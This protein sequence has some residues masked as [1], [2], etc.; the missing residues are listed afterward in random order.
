MSQYFIDTLV[1][2]PAPKLMS[3]LRCLI[4]CEKWAQCSAVMKHKL[5]Y[6]TA[7][8]TFGG[9]NVSASSS[10]PAKCVKLSGINKW[11]LEIWLIK[12]FSETLTFD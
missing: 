5:Q 3:P 7:K 4:K 11:I 10:Y 12:S 9:E 8:L 6:I 2:V 1:H